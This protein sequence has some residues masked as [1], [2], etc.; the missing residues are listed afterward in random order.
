MPVNVRPFDPA[1]AGFWRVRELTYNSGKPIPEEDRVVKNTLAYVAEDGGEIVG[2]YNVLELT[3]T[4]RGGVLNCGGIAA[5]AVHPAI[6]GS[7][8][9]S[10]MMRSAIRDMRDRGVQMASL[11]AYREWYYRR[12]GYETC[13]TRYEIK[14]PEG[15]WPHLKPEL[16]VQA[17]E[18][19][20]YA[21]IVACYEKFARA[22]NGM[23]L[24]DERLWQRV[25]SEKNVV[26]VAGEPAE[27]YAIVQ[28]DWSF[29]KEQ[30]IQE[31]GWTTRRG[32]EAI[33][34]LITNIGVNKTRIEWYE[35]GDS[36]FFAAY[37]D[38]GVEVK[39]SRSIM[40][41]TTD[42]PAALRE[43]RSSGTGSFTLRV[44]DSVVPENEGPWRV[45]FSPSGV[46]V[47]ACETAGLE[48][49]IQAFTQALLGEPSLE[50]L[51]RNGL[52]D[53]RDQADLEGAKT[54]LPPARTYCMEFF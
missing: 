17:L 40:F 42:V 33:L 14:C 18:P 9:G 1:D 12:F 28:H 19:G 16:D 10:A 22:R 13:G 26:Y 41:R 50:D 51:A 29:W 34:A 11:Y 4:C 2:S 46:I 6:R 36:P 25:V 38:Q 39:V 21:P 48:M 32:Y 23:S 27:A 44:H 49:T 53:V 5:V 30:P 35:P 31:I 54:L 47:E 24:R 20:D 8:V 15:R 43:V 3:C 52:V 45:S 7:G 37:L